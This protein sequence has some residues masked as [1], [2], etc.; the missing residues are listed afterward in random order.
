MN[1]RQ[2][3]KFALVG[4][5]GAGSGV[6]VLTTCFK[7]ALRF[8]YKPRHLSSDQDRKSA[9]PWVYTRLDPDVSANL[10]YLNYNQ[11]GCMYGAFKSIIAQLGEKIGEPFKSFPYHMMKYGS[12]GIGDYGAVCGAL[13]GAGAVIGL[14]VRN[15]A[16]RKFLI[17]DLFSWYENSVLPVYKPKHPVLNMKVTPSV[18][19]SI[20]CHV[21]A[22]RWARVSGFRLKSKEQ[23]ERCRCLTADVVRKTVAMLNDFFDDQY[24][25]SDKINSDA[26]RCK[27]CHNKGGKLENSRGQMSCT[28]CHSTSLPHKI[29]AD[30]HYKLLKD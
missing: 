24:V 30:I 16:H 8:D 14:L 13:N 3:I 22:A 27:N 4:L 26:A 7:P 9:L 20:L 25:T 15:G 11:G 23:S 12:G 6:T 5:A 29:F 2:F 1:R 19:N 28:S 10:A 21:S 18:S 17:S